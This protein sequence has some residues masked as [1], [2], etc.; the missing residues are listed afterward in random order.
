MKDDTVS[1][2][3]V[4]AAKKLADGA[5]ELDED[6]QGE[7]VRICGD[8]LK[9]SEDEN[10]RK[11]AANALLTLYKRYRRS[12]VRAFNGVFI[13]ERSV[14]TD[15]DCDSEGCGDIDVLDS[16]LPKEKIFFSIEEE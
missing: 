8:A 2:V 9:N 1:A 15:Y 4:A 16:E 14:H 12:E 7:L 6:L 3:R 5:A 13:A 11:T 10:V